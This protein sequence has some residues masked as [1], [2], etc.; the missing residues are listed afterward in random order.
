MPCWIWVLGYYKTT[1]TYGSFA[2]A[3]FLQEN[4]FGIAKFVH[5]AHCNMWYGCSDPISTTPLSSLFYSKLHGGKV[6]HDQGTTFFLEDML[7][8]T[9]IFYYVSPEDF[10][11]LKKPEAAGA[12]HWQTP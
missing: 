12:L 8:I 7:Q 11:L 2:K 3:L 4:L 5:L 6:G 1:H 9:K 10:L